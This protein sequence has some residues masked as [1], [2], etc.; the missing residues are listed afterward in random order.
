MCIVLENL[1]SVD[2]L[3]ELIDS[4]LKE[5]SELKFRINAKNLF[6]TYPY[7]P[8]PL[9]VVF[10]QLSSKL[11]K[12]VIESFFFV[13]EFHKTSNSSLVSDHIHV[14]LSLKYKVDFKNPRCFDLTSLDHNGSL[15]TYHGRYEKVRKMEESMNY[16][17]KDLKSS[18]VA[19]KSVLDNTD[20]C[21]ISDDIKDRIN[22]S[23][24]FVNNFS[25]YISLAKEGRFS[26]LNTLYEKTHDKDYFKNSSKINSSAHYLR[27][28][29]LRDLENKPKYTLD[30]FFP[31][32]YIYQSLDIAFSQKLNKKYSFYIF[33]PSN[34][35]KTS[36][37]LSFLSSKS[38]SFFVSKNLSS[39]KERTGVEDVVIFDDCSLDYIRDINELI[40]LL[41][42][43]NS[44]SV[45]ILYG[46]NSFF[47]C[48]KIFLDNYTPESKFDSY[49][50]REP[51]CN[52]RVLIFPLPNISLFNDFSGISSDNHL[53]Y[54]DILSNFLHRFNID[55]SDKTFMRTKLSISY[56]FDLKTSKIIRVPN[57]D[58]EDFYSKNWNR[59]LSV[60]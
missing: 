21:L 59:Y 27:Q 10:E 16:L 57:Q 44:S 36:F 24:D 23:G 6:L 29:V 39:L 38:L 14:C 51:S 4:P 28:K 11:E 18:V 37:L 45:R 3:R 60:E 53:E 31:T 5:T 2:F 54:I 35:G 52:R 42:V 15:L 26:K 20:I 48:T 17:L 13:K 19:D 58:L 41:E 25:F 34:V 47:N 32:S 40:N 43:E 50:W 56:I 9:S 55:K 33:G 30:S 12:K 49:N 1:K 8:L 22:S 46:I 7:C